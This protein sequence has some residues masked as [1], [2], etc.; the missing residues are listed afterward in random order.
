MQMVAAAKLRRAQDATEAARPYSERFNSA[1]ALASSVGSAESAPKHL[2]GT[3]KGDVIFSF[4][5]TAERG[6]AVSLTQTLR[7]QR[8]HAAELK[9]KGKTVKV[10]TVGKKGRDSLK[11][12]L[13]ENFI[14]MW[15]RQT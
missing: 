10:L 5:M 13:G 7:S 14:I 9:A 3:G 4:V 2:S 8:N 12:D 1:A 11:R 6:Y 15:T